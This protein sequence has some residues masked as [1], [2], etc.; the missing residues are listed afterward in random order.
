M[1]LCI[2]TIVA[3]TVNFSQSTYSVAEHIGPLEPILL[4]SNPVSINFTVNI[5]DRSKT[6]IGEF[7]VS[8][9]Y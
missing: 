1:Y 2:I 7:K 4:L 8:I 6:A 3:S 9:G 5:K